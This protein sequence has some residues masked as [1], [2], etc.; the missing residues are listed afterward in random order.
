MGTFVDDGMKSY[1][2]QYT[3]ELG[4]SAARLGVIGNQI[5]PINDNND[6]YVLDRNALNYNAF[7]WGFVK[8]LKEN[9]V[10]QFILTIWSVPAW[11]KKNASEDY[12][13]ANALTW[14]E[15]DN[16]VDTLMYEEYA[17][18]VVAIIKS[19][20][21]MAGVDIY[22]I[23]LQNEPAFCE[24]Y[25]SAI[26]S[27]RLF[28]KLINMVGKRFELE[29]I[30]CRLYMAEQVLGIPLYEWRSY[31]AAVQNDTEAWRYSDVQAVHGYAGDGIT[32]FTADCAQWKNYLK[33]VE[34][35]PHPKEFWM[36]ETEIPSKTWS[37]VMV[38]VGAMSTAFTCGN[39]SWWTQWGYSGHYTTQGESNQLTYAEAQFAKFVKPGA[40]RVSATSSNDSL[41]VSSFVNTAKHGKNLATVIINK[42]ETPKSIKLTGNDI[43]ATFDVYQTFELQNFKNTPGGMQ[44]GSAY[45]LPPQSI[46]TFV[47]QLPNAAPTIDAVADQVVDNNSGEQMITLTGITDGGE[48]NQVLSLKTSVLTG[49][50]LI[51]NVRVEYNSPENTAKLYFTPVLDKKGNA[52][53]KIE[54]SDD[55][56]INNMASVNCNIQI[57]SP[58][59]VKNIDINELKL[60]PNPARSEIALKNISTE[61]SCSVMIMN[62]NGQ[63]LKQIKSYSGGMI[64]IEDLDAGIYMVRII[65]K[66]N[67]PNTLM[68]IKR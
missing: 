24:P 37:D 53:V 22:G 52:S 59:S 5:E 51:S 57:L 50:T 48:G 34:K 7:D 54:L 29:G 10:E 47:A 6:P 61:G 25:P 36:T 60:F 2:K 62:I 20:K 19:F 27:P 4:A 56:A 35:A 65:Q 16:R 18:Y 9:G 17:E 38:N 33:E 45:L 1:L 21:E 43:P 39:I 44:K 13:M 26:L 31:L 49:G 63:V 3:Q 64:N 14:E 46:T 11:M 66:N 8:Q 55:G 15:T 28:V 30:N 23:G 12:F 32:A 42:A 58:T 67:K 40:V 68:F 41:L